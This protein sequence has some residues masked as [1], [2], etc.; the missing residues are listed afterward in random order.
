MG[1]TFM[2]LFI[3]YL[4]SLMLLVEYVEKIKGSSKH[5]LINLLIYSFSFFFSY[6]FWALQILPPLTKISS[7]RFV[8]KGMYAHIVLGTY[9]QTKK[10]RH[11]A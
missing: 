10:S 2:Y 6:Q 8:R 1:C 4:H 9:A 7:S 3:C 11:D 5:P